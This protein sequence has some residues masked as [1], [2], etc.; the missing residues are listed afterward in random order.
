MTSSSC[1]LSPFTRISGVPM[2]LHDS[3]RSQFSGHIFLHHSAAFSRVDHFLLV[4]SGPS[5]S[6]TSPSTLLAIPS[7]PSL[8]V[9]SQLPIST[10]WRAPEL[11]LQNSFILY[12][13]LSGFSPLL[14]PSRILQNIML[15]TF[16]IYSVYDNFLPSLP[17][18]NS[19]LNIIEIIEIAS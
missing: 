12:F 14:P 18:R 7:Q 9:C 2:F 16:K 6:L 13:W 10:C 19:L 11:S 5:V 17:Y 1:L 4:A 3:L 8:Q 15:T